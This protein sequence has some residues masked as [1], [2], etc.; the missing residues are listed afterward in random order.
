MSMGKLIQNLS[1]LLSLGPFEKFVWWWC[2]KV[3]LVIGFGPSLDLGTGTQDKADQLRFNHKQTWKYWCILVSWFPVG[4]YTGSRILIKITALVA[5]KRSYGIY[6][7]VS[8]HQYANF[9]NLLPHFS[10]RLT[11]LTLN[12]KDQTGSRIF[13]TFTY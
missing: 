9:T 4:F 7:S 8:F 5:T 3:N 11:P 10:V 1:L 6:R 12:Y 2:L 13:H